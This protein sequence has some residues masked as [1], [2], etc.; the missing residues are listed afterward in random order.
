[1][2]RNLL[3]CGN[4]LIVL[5]ESLIQ[6]VSYTIQ[7]PVRTNINNVLMK[8]QRRHRTRSVHVNRLKTYYGAELY[9][10]AQV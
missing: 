2:P 4:V 6:S 9:H 10:P 5:F 3:R 8:S 7:P 1:M